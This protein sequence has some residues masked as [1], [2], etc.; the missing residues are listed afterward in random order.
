MHN[1]INSCGISIQ[2]FHITAGAL[3]TQLV[4]L[5][6]YLLSEHSPLRSAGEGSYADFFLPIILAHNEFG[7]QMALAILLETF[8]PP[9]PLQKRVYRTE[10]PCSPSFQRDSWASWV[11]V[12]R[13]FPSLYPGWRSREDA[14]SGA[15]VLL[16]VR[17]NLQG[18][19][20]GSHLRT[21]H[22]PRWNWETISNRGT[23]SHSRS[24]SRFVDHLPETTT[25]Q[26]WCV[27]EV[28]VISLVLFRMR[29]VLF[30]YR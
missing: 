23:V 26:P 16:R 13:L 3:Y 22:G 9:L 18:E 14:Y 30:Q 10:Q 8:K 19:F 2:N 1:S 28:G 6:R 7:L 17:S 15:T 11:A 29:T 4:K 5:S 24:C 21:H 25:A 27:S 12:V 20:A